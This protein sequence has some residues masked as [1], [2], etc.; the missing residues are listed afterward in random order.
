MYTLSSY[1]ILVCY[2]LFDS[3]YPAYK[4]VWPN[5][6]NPMVV[7]LSLHILIHAIGYQSAL[8]LSSSSRNAAFSV[9]SSFFPSLFGFWHEGC[10]FHF[11]YL[12][13]T[14][15]L[16]MHHVSHRLHLVSIIFVVW[17][18]H[19]FSFLECT[20]HTRIN[21]IFEQIIW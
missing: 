3:I 21:V 18:F 10:A 14:S 17:C 19:M 8:K 15:H 6:V 11:I 20:Q 1:F 4:I 7:V 9:F 16:V 13:E 5:V 12:C 2:L